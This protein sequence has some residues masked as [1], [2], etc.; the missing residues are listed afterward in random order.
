M[1][2]FGATGTDAAQG[3]AGSDGWGARGLLEPW[4]LGHLGGAVAVVALLA[5]TGWARLRGVRRADGV[6]WWMWLN[7]GLA[8]W[9]AM[10]A[11]AGLAA[12]AV[13]QGA[14]GTPC[15]QA[16]TGLVA[17]GLGLLCALSL[18]HHLAGL[19]PGAGLRVR[20]RGLLLGLGLGLLAWPIVQ[21]VSLLA[22]AAHRT[23]TGEGHERLS[24]PTL[25]SIVENPGDPWA[26]TVVGLAVLAA[27]VFEEVLY[28]GFV[29]TLALRATGKP[30][31]AV[32][33][34][35]AVFTAAHLGTGM[36]WYA[37]LTI[38][39]LGAAMGWAFERT[40]G[41]GAPIAMHVVFNGANVGLALL[42]A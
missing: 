31:L 36:A 37:L 17:Y 38:G 20:V 8:S 42:T 24:H 3:G 25:R 41:L 18:A 30:W 40:K 4:A 12:W 19:T 32:L 2:A 9:L 35:T 33:L 5:W 21:S 39:T 23:A 16:V 10:G 34:S 26:W 11:G 22:V 13:G 29:Q 15:G 14:T 1:A 27:P 28:R 7:A 6:A